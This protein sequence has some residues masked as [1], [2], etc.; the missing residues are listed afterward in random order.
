MSRFVFFFFQAEDGIRDIGVNGVQDVC[1]SD[2]TSSRGSCC[3][4]KFDSPMFLKFQSLYLIV[5]LY[6]FFIIILLILC[7]FCHA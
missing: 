4:D 2:L 6:L 7:R 3:S 5:W 1:S